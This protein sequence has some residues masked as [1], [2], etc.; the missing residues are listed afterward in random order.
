MKDRLSGWN[1]WGLNIKNVIKTILKAHEDSRNFLI[2]NLWPTLCPIILS[3]WDWRM[4]VSHD[5]SADWNDR[6]KCWRDFLIS[7][8]LFRLHYLLCTLP[9]GVLA[10]SFPDNGPMETGVL[11]FVPALP[12]KQMA[13]PRGEHARLLDFLYERFLNK[14][15]EEIKDIV[16]NNVTKLISQP[17]RAHLVFSG[18][19]NFK[20][21]CDNKPT[22]NSSTLWLIPTDVS[23]N[24]QSYAVAIALPSANKQKNSWIY[25]NE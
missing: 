20:R 17:S 14:S 23:M 13:P 19:S 5:I 6:R 25:V 11:G 21:I 15:L 4:Y 18:F 7:L 22:S 12:D 24:L 1:G 2:W 3:L 16:S 8:L 10:I 9:G